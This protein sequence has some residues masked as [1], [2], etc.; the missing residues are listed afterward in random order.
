[1]TLRNCIE[2]FIRHFF[3]S[4]ALTTFSSFFQP[5]VFVPFRDPQRTPSFVSALPFCVGE[6]S[7]AKKKQCRPRG[8]RCPVFFPL[9][10][11]SNPP[12]FA[13]ATG[14]E[15]HGAGG[16]GRGALGAAERLAPGPGEASRARFGVALDDTQTPVATSGAPF[17]FFSRLFFGGVA[18]FST[19]WRG[20]VTVATSQGSLNF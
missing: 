15:A 13:A 18:F 8:S 2:H 5:S 11:S 9:S 12:L 6:R 7:K 10:A 1:M 17:L 19:F 3:P 20:L 4:S 14:A 16:R